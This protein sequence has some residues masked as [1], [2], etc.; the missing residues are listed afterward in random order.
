MFA[1]LIC[2]WT[3]SH[4]RGVRFIHADY[5]STADAGKV[6]FYCPRCGATWTRKEREQRKARKGTV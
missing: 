3:G 1:K 5:T 6:H 4:K 2:W